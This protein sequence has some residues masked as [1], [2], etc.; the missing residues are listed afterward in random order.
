MVRMRDRGAPNALQAESKTPADVDLEELRTAAAADRERHERAWTEAYQQLRP[1]IVSVLRR[2]GIRDHELED[3]AATVWLHVIERLNTIRSP[4]RLRSW[5][6]RV[7]ERV[8][9]MRGRAAARAMRHDAGAVFVDLDARADNELSDPLE[10]IERQEQRAA[11]RAKI[12]T[13]DADSQHLYRL[14]YEEACGD[15]EVAAALGTTRANLRQRRR[16]LVKKLQK[17]LSSL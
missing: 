2:H 14:C 7:A 15:E 16:A 4:E 1:W 6:A 13:L 8:A 9:L 12:L 11:V 17:L 10:E 5:I 3:A